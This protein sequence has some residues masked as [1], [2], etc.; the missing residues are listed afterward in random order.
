MET[1]LNKPSRQQRSEAEIKEILKEYE[2]SNLT[3]R[4]FCELYSI[5]EQTLYNWRNKYYPK[6]EEPG[7][8]VT[9]ELATPG[10]AGIFAELEMQGK[11]LRFF[12]PV[13]AEFFKALM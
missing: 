5:S 6:V 7:H 10:A 4:E 11:T 1:I 12:Q 2:E 13:S 9:M 3:V 8:F